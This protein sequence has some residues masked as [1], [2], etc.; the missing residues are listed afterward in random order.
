MKKLLSLVCVL[1]LVLS[2][3]PATLAAEPVLTAQG[4]FETICAELTGVTDEQVTAVKYT[5][6][7]GTETALTGEDF[8]Y[9]VRDMDGGVRIDIPGIK[10]GTYTL[11]VTAGE[12]YTA[13][14]IQVKAYDRSGYAHKVH[15]V[16]SEGNIT[17][18]Q[19]Y[20]EGVGAYNDDGT[21]K[22]DAVVLY[23]TDENKNDVTLQATR[24]GEPITATGIGNILN[25]NNK[26]R[27]DILEFLSKENKKPLVVRFI[28]TVNAPEGVSA[29]KM[30]SSNGGMVYM[31][32][33]SNI[34]LEGIG[35]D[36]VIHGWGFSF[37]ANKDDSQYQKW[38][39][40]FEA[41][42]LTFKETPEDAMEITGFP[43]ADG[44]IKESV[45]HAWVHNCAF[46]RPSDIQNPAESDKVQ[47]DGALDFKWGR[48]MTMSY[49]YFERNHKTSLIGAGDTNQQY[50]IT[51]HHN[52]WKNVESR[53]PLCRQSNV[54]IYNNLY[55]GQSGY[56]MSLRADCY[57]FSEYNTFLNC[58]D[59]VKDEGSGGVCKSFGDVFTGCAGANNAQI[60]QD[61]EM[62]VES[63]SRY[64]AFEYD[65]KLSYIPFGDYLLEENVEDAQAVIA[66]YTGV[67]KPLAQIT[68]P[69]VH[70]HVWSPWTVTKANTCTEGGHRSRTCTAE[71]CPLGGAAQE[72]DSVALG[73]HWG[74]WEETL[75]E[76]TCATEGSRRRSCI[77]NNDGAT[78]T[79]IIP[80]TGH[81][82]D[83]AGTCAVCGGLNTVE[84]H[85]FDPASAVAG[86]SV[87]ADS[88]FTFHYA[89]GTLNPNKKSFAD[90]TSS[91]RV[92]TGSSATAG[93]NCI[94]FTTTGPATVKIYWGAAGEGRQMMILDSAG[95]EVAVTQ[96]ESV[97]NGLYTSVLTL[98]KAGTYHLGSK[99]G[100]NYIYGFRV[101]CQQNMLQEGTLGA[102]GDALIWS[103]TENG[104]FNLGGLMPEDDL[105]L[106]T[107]WD[108]QGRFAGVKF[109]DATHMGT[110]LGTGWSK[111]KLFWTNGEK[112]QPQCQAVTAWGGTD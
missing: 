81:T 25:N 12:T 22:D 108:D 94:S 112:Q 86:S 65:P 47:G 7:D 110:Q 35:P 39:R 53:A 105:V 91:Y 6:A 41:R 59:P 56:C 84:D 8:D 54:H 48:Y 61:R 70:H 72:E 68:H 51:W 26:V 24:D 45:E 60:V 62:A 57:I 95:A 97:K 55:D 73:H 40:N 1:A 44:S 15:T 88:F 67:M 79:G 103:Y 27:D 107:C 37:G 104:T 93:S 11:T 74:P 2:L 111:V 21:L 36:A 38:A 101:A 3:V 43:N 102:E 31:L 69:E 14:N 89:A 10:A 109:L 77:R 30:G 66:A 19:D 5:D 87:P 50:H 29:F 64:A 4:W 28:G 58:K 46:Y 106:A 78:D 82:F 76:A 18:I 80:A 9:L 16:D 100:S 34:T 83:D 42:N 52:W 98:D 63:E 75:K 13:E 92:T 17:G 85:L 33:G 49:N 96:E 20:T 23:V 99:G 71:G 32:S 90:Y